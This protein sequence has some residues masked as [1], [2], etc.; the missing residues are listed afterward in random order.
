MNKNL[1]TALFFIGASIAVTLLSLLIIIIPNVIL[2]LIMK[3]NFQRIA[4]IS[5]TI[6]FLGAIIGSFAIYSK[7]MKTL[8]EKVDLGKYFSSWLIKKKEETKN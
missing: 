8:S 2:A 7:I 5:L 4:S 3:E 1:N 6:S